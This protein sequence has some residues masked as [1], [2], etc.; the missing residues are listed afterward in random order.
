MTRSGFIEGLEEVLG[1]PKRTLKEDD[2]RETVASWTSLADARIFALIHDQ[3]GLEPDQELIE[4][5]SVED[6]VGALENKGAF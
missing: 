5:E 4:A 1:L 6:L 3:F 2:T